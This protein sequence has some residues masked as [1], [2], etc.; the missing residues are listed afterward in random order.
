M[1]RMT[2]RVLRGTCRRRKM[3]KAEPA[4]LVSWQAS[5]KPKR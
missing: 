4:G 2:A 5:V 1:V 3:G